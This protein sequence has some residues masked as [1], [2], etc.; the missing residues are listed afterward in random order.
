MECSNTSRARCIGLRTPIKDQH[1]IA[2]FIDDMT[3]EKHTANSADSTT[4]TVMV[5]NRSITFDRTIHGEI[6]P[7]A[8][9]GDLLIFKYFDGNLD[10]VDSGG[11]VIQECHG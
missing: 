4:A 3:V 8:C 7:K 1:P 6:T 10:G 11:T 9:I 2:K 5:D